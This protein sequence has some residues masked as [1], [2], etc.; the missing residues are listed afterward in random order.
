MVELYE[1]KDKSIM[2]PKCGKFLAKAD[3]RDP[4]V[5]KLVCRHCKKW[6]WFKPAD[7]DYRKIKDVPE[8]VSSSGKIFY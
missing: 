5:H 1:N 2:C 6:I 3:A 8:R 4:R 7:D